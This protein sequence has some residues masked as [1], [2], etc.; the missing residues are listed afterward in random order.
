MRIEREENDRLVN[1]Y[2]TQNEILD[3]QNRL[4]Q[5]KAQSLE[6]AVEARDKEIAELREDTLSQ[7]QEI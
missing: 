6:A 7:A 5:D 1:L 4:N 2:R 3:T